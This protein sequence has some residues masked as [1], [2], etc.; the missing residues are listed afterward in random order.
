MNKRIKILYTIPNF[1]TAGSQYVLLSL[2]RNI[3]KTIF[4][5]Y[6][7][8]E[9]H[10]DAVPN[11]I[12]VSHIIVFKW[13]GNKTNDV[14]KFRR[15]L[16]KAKIDIVHSWDYKSNY[17][18]ALT[19]KV[20]GVNYLYTKKNNTW[21]KRWLFKSLLSQ[22]IAYDNPEMKKRFFDSIFLRFPGTPLWVA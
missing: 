2:F 3:D 12:L 10:P 17:L 6:I 11:D 4:D 16:K 5:P 13:T 7:C 9:N 22:H 20:A 19:Y 8:I 18:E 15:I 14:L 1:K 21:S